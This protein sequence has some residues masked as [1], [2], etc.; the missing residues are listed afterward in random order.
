MSKY[1][2]KY[3]EFTILAFAL[4]FAMLFQYVRISNLD[5]AFLY[6]TSYVSYILYTLIILLVPILVLLFVFAPLLFVFEL[7]YNIHLPKSYDIKITK[8]IYSIRLFIYSIIRK[9][10]LYTVL[11][12]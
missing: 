1:L 7:S 8:V 9:P 3:I 11:R 2:K 10:R 4:L 5:I 6:E 12:C